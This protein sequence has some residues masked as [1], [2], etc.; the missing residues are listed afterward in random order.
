MKNK[1]TAFLTGFLLIFNLAFADTIVLTKNKATYVQEEEFMLA[2]G[3]N[4][5]GPIELHPLN[6]LEILNF[7]IKDA[8]VVDYIYEPSSLNWKENLIGKE[9]VISGDG[10]VFK[11]KVIDIK[12]DFIT[13]DTKKGVIIV[14]T[15]TFPSKIEIKKSYSSSS[16][17]K[18]TFKVVSKIAGESKIKISYPIK[19]ISWKVRYLQKDGKL[20]GFLEIENNTAFTFASVDILV[21][22]LNKK[23]E[24]VFLPANS[25]K[26]IK[27]NTDKKLPDG[28][29]FIY[30][31]GIFKGIGKV[32]SGKLIR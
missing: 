4:I 22:P 30:E 27:F 17:P 3:E 19:G 2:E 32:K 31:K 13:L 12:K 10:R 9:I 7:D 25:K 21:K 16:S 28:I 1:I 8:E 24:K 20:T 29:V 6:T 15:P 11:G 14:P 23:L 26:I 18:I 5:L